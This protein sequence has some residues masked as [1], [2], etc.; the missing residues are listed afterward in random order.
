MDFS[1]VTGA[2]PFPLPARRSSRPEDRGACASPEGTEEKPSIFKEIWV[3]QIFQCCHL[4]KFL[5]I[6]T[7]GLPKGEM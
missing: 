7:K 4:N 6:Y 1:E 3:M 2:P 5:T